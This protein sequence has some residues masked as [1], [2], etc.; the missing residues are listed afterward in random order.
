MKPRDP[1][2]VERVTAKIQALRAALASTNDETA[3][4]RRRIRPRRDSVVPEEHR[5]QSL[6]APEG[7]TP[8]WDA[9]QAEGLSIRLERKAKDDPES[10]KR[11][12]RRQVRRAAPIVASLPDVG[13]HERRKAWELG[14]RAKSTLPAAQLTRRKFT[15]TARAFREAAGRYAPYAVDAPEQEAVSLVL[16]FMTIPMIET[17]FADLDARPVRRPGYVDQGLRRFRID[18]VRPRGAFADDATAERVAA[19]LGVFPVG[20]TPR[21]K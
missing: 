20:P 10:I 17:L 15:A 12:H 5:P 14:R 18:T 13:E 19:S 2:L 1:A 11:D 7:R 16:Q 9:L 4:P 6:I 3:P 21:N 8:T